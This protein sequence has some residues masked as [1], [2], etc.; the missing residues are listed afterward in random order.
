MSALPLVMKWDGESFTP[1]GRYAKEADANFVVGEVYRLVE[2]QERSSASHSHYFAALHDAFHNL[3]EDQSE[4]FNSVEHLRHYALI[5][6][7]FANTRQ[8]VCASAAMAQRTAD[9][10]R[11]MASFEIITATE[12]VVTV[13]TA[14]SQSMKAMDKREFQASKQAVLDYVAGLIGVAPATLSREAGKA[15]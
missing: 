5:K 3:P 8:I 9:F 12:A 14:K 1:V 4:R 6:C 10:I 15:A 2:V 11:P 7:G 13:Y